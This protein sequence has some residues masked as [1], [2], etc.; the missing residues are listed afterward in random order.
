MP[1]RPYLGFDDANRDFVIDTLSKHL[2][3]AMG[4]GAKE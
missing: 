2:K 1:A 3:G 4:A